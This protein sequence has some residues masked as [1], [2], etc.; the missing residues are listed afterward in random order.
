MS[1]VMF[2]SVEEAKAYIDVKAG[3][4]KFDTQLEELIKLSSALIS[5]ECRRDFKEQQYTQYFGTVSNTNTVYDLVGSYTNEGGLSQTTH[6]QRLQLKSAPINLSEDLSVYYDPSRAFP[7]SSLLTVNTQYYIDEE[8]EDIILTVATVDSNRAVKIVYTA[9]YVEEDG[10]LSASLPQ[11]LKSACITQT[12]FLFDKYQS[13]SIGVSSQTEEQGK[14]YTT[15]KSLLTPEVMSLIRPYRTVL[16][17]R[18]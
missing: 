8:L 4:T 16:F 15:P 7:E 12:A 1:E 17:G 10:T 3:T 14:E 2:V 6:E 11:V 18:R 13:N 5:V 9:G